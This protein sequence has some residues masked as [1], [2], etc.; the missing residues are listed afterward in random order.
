MRRDPNWRDVAVAE[1][2]TAA[3]YY[4]EAQNALEQAR[5][6]LTMAVRDGYADGLRKFEI[7]DA[8]DGLWS[9]QWIDRVLH[10]VE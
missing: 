9:R 1:L 10:E 3:R 7:F 5:A 6:D 2:Q 8:I 4:R